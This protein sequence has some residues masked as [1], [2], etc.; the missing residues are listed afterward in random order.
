[1]KRFL[2][3][4]LLH[5]LLLGATLFVAYGFLN[6]TTNAPPGELIVSAGQLEHLTTTFARFQQRPPTAGELKGLI[7]QYVREEVMSR[8][9]VKLGLDRDDT[10][11]RRRLQQKMEFVANDLAAATEPTEAELTT[12]LAD[13]PDNFR[14]ERQFSFRH[15]FVSPEKRGAHLDAD[16]SGLLKDLT[17]G[18]PRADVNRLGDSFL[19]PCEFTGESQSAIAA[20]FGS[21]FAAQLAKVN[22]GEW[23]GPIRS[24]YGAHL[25]LLTARTES[26]LPS[27]DEVRDSVKR[28]WMNERRLNANRH[29]FDAMLAKY[30]VK[31]ELPKAEAVN[32]HKTVAKSL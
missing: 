2:K 26:R 21:D 22:I 28:D 8:E 15:V 4:P 31:I 20:H 25:V 5:F 16:I 24:G 3:E 1:M 14:Q 27:L 17:E 29:F 12:W 11:I 7:D 23:A 19:L 18:G 10:I 32:A 30:R 9:A 13:H 6:Q